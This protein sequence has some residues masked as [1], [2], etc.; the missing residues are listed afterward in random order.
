M[1]EGSIRIKV[2][3][4]EFEVSGAEA[5]VERQFAKL[6]EL[7]AS[8]TRDVGEATQAGALGEAVRQAVSAP[9]GE[10]AGP[11]G[12]TPGGTPALQDFYKGCAPRTAIEQVTVLAAYLARHNNVPEVSAEVLEPHFQMLA[13]HGEKVPGNVRAAIWNAAAKGRGYLRRVQGKKNAYELTTAGQALVSSK[14][15]ERAKGRAA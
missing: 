9:P 5:F 6:Q 3:S 15:P 2:G 12:S 10:P 14:L 13:V 1:V 7:M 4:L 8:G 11:G